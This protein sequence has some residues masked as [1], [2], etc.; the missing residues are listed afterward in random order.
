VFFL[1]ML[2]AYVRYARAASITRYLV[3]AVL[4]AAGLMSKPMLVSAPVV[5]LL[6]DYWPLRRFEQ[7]SSTK[8]KPKI[9]KSANQRRLIQRLVLEK[10]PLLVLSAG[11]CVIT[12]V[13]QKR[14]TGAIPP[15]RF[16]WR[17]QNAFASYAI[18]VWETLWPTHLAVFY[19]H[20]ND[21]LAVWEI[22]LAIGFLLAVTVA[23]VVF[24]SER[25]YLFTGWFWYLGMLVPVIGLV[26]VG[27]Q[28]HADRYTYL[29]QVGLYIA[30]TWA[31]ADLT[32]SF[33]QRILLGAAALLIIG[34][35]SWTAWIHTSY[36]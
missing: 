29:P 7:P 13:L 33:R 18:Y 10:I 36:W 19:P 27:E 21:T 17:V 12:F 24:R 22:I 34:A 16:L 25:P 1:L 4:F 23:A 9:L 35:L 15:L 6:L 11:A 14:A 20:P 5:L 31:V 8:R 2:D 28:G 32:A 30:G 26:Q 3:V